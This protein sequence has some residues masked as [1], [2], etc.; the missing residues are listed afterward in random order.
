MCVSPNFVWVEKGPSYEKQQVPCRGCWR[1]Q[2]RRVNDY[3]G[4]CL[5]EAA[6]SDWVVTLT[7]TYA[8]RTDLA[9]KE[10]TP[11]HFQQFVRKLRRRGY[12]FRYFV[13]GEY[14]EL[15]GRAHFHCI[16]FGTGEK[17][18]H[19]LF[20]N[21]ER[22]YPGEAERLWDRERTEGPQYWP[23]GQNFHCHEWPHGHVFAD[24]RADVR[25]IRYAAKYLN[26]REPGRHWFSLSK[27]PALGA[28]HFEELADRAV[29]FGVLPSTLEYIAPGDTEGKQRYLL[30]GA[31]RRDYLLRIIDGW[32]EHR[33]L[34]MD[35]CNEWVRKMIEKAQLAR[36]VA[37]G[38][39]EP[40]E[41]Y[42]D[43][44]RD[45]LA[46]NRPSEQS[47]RANVRATDP[48]VY[49]YDVTRDFDYGSQGQQER[50]TQDP[51]EHP[52]TTDAGTEDDARTS[53]GQPAPRESR[54]A[55][56]H[57]QRHQPHA[58][59]CS[60]LS[61]RERRPGYEAQ[62]PGGGVYHRAGTPRLPHSDG[63]R[64]QW[65]RGTKNHPSG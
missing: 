57:A 23:Q 53:G 50:G 39:W 16:L 17:P 26:K 41:E 38:E 42:L 56:H 62:N 33:P 44:L 4:R 35:T 37:E 10:L 7:L 58:L 22:W 64:P 43:K 3:V 2:K 21:S 51:R 24:W 46:K 19:K 5:A 59:E 30:S 34:D 18:T 36:D 9:D 14:G 55:G 63:Q 20:E 6:H 48:W 11:K 29:E 40:I 31:S 12:V 65:D 60:G 1:C 52:A 54:S 45:Q 28:A 25:T 13:A 61:P 49:A 27:K 8:P 32:A 15:R 47:V